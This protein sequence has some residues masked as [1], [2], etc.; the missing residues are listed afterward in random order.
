M[1]QYWIHV[2]DL[3][4]FQHWRVTNT[5]NLDIDLCRFQHWRVKNIYYW[6]NN[7]LWLP[8][9]INNYSFNLLMWCN[10]K[11]MRILTKYREETNSYWLY[12]PKKA[13]HHNVIQACWFWITEHMWIK[14]YMFEAVV[15]YYY[16]MSN[17][18]NWI[19]TQN[20][21]LEK[22]CHKVKNTSNLYIQSNHSHIHKKILQNN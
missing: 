3:C 13:P 19:R 14:W 5:F 12:D 20:L 10:K 22:Q 11:F 17:T 21:G 15:A 9:S 1:S 6:K 16:C 4:R 8:S 7:N 2:L 18:S